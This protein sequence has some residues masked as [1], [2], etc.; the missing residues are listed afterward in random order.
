MQNDTEGKTGNPSVVGVQ[1]SQ[2][3]HA[4]WRHEVT[5]EEH[6]GHHGP[7]ERGGRQNLKS[8]GPLSEAG[9]RCSSLALVFENRVKGRR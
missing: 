7:T 2:C 3:E 8:A 9:K 4:S 6:A 1:W 5:N